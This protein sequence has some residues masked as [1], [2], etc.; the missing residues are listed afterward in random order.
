MPDPLPD[1]AQRITGGC[2]CGAVRYALGVEPDDVN[3]CHC[4]MCQKASGGPFMAFGTVPVARIEWTR[5]APSL[6]RSSSFAERGFCPA[7]GTPL[8]YQ[9]NERTISITL[10]SLD[11][12]AAVRPTVQ[13]GLEAR[14]AWIGDLADMP[15]ETTYSWMATAAR[16]AFVNRQ[17]PDHDD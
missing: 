1:R 10:G 11:R 13:L 7:C 4:R 12:P 2:Q 14:L 15:A 5:G 17:H 16:A 9:S 6:F 8:T 3:V